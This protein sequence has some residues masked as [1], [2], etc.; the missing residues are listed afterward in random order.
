MV[1]RRRLTK[2]QRLQVYEKYDGK[3][4]YCGSHISLDEMQ[5]D[6]IKPL[7]LGGADDISNFAPACRMCNFYKST[8]TIEKFRE[9]LGLLKGRLEKDFT[10]RLALKYGLIRECNKPVDFFFERRKDEEAEL[11][12]RTLR[13]KIENG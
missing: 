3:C 11:A 13:L 12:E 1:K 7:A 2:A 10:Y 8:L 6:H 9:Q 5:V 4:A